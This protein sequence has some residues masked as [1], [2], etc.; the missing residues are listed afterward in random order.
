MRARHVAYSVKQSPAQKQACM[1]AVPTAQVPVLQ[2]GSMN[3]CWPARQLARTLGNIVHGEDL[4]PLQNG[5]CTVTQQATESS[6]CT[7][8]RAGGSNVRAK[9]HAASCELLIHSIH[10][11][12]GCSQQDGKRLHAYIAIDL[13][14]LPPCMLWI[15]G[16]GCAV[17]TIISR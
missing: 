2:A 9:Q 14:S 10:V 7:L 15:P 3:K 8:A 16:L 17:F 12:C 4:V 13:P 5:V 6:R 1:W 11:V